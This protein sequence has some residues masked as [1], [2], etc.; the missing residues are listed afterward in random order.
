M[1]PW[2]GV[3][4]NGCLIDGCTSDYLGDLGGQLVNVPPLHVI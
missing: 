3:M 4:G 2:A 1:K